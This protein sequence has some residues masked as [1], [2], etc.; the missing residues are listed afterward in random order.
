VD[1]AVS[2]SGIIWTKS[3]RK[4]YGEGRGC[5]HPSVEFVACPVC[6][7]MPGGLCTGVDGEPHL[8]RHHKRCDR[9]RAWSM[10]PKRRDPRCGMRGCRAYVTHVLVSHVGSNVEPQLLCC[11]GCSLLVRGALGTFRL[12]SATGRCR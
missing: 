11:Y 6:Y 4:I 2:A 8:E 5:A 3:P 10:S 7:S 1:A 12:F 9:Y